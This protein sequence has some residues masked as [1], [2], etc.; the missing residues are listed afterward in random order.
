MSVSEANLSSFVAANAVSL[1]TI[2]PRL[3]R[4]D[5]LKTDND[6]AKKAALFVRVRGADRWGFPWTQKRILVLT[7]RLL[8]LLSSVA[9]RFTALS[10]RS[11]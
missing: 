3:S 1:L 9:V 6:V 11:A 7:I 8:K 5:N 4:G 10:K 2:T